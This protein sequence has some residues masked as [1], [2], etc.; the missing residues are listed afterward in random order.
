MNDRNNLEG[1]DLDSMIVPIINF[2][3]LSNTGYANTNTNKS[4]AANIDEALIEMMASFNPDELEEKYF[5]QATL[6]LDGHDFARAVYRTYLKREPEDPDL[7]VDDGVAI[8]TAFV[9]IVRTCPEYE[10]RKHENQ[11]QNQN[12]YSKLKKMVALLIKPIYLLIR[13]IYMILAKLLIESLARLNP[14]KL[15]DELFVLL[16]Y[17]LNCRDFGRSVYRTYLKREPDTDVSVK[18]NYVNRIVF[19]TRVR[20]SSEYMSLW[21]SH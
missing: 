6:S 16:T 7:R 11:N 9:N 2:T 17:I 3:S 14:N 4:S 20:K 8:R 10:N 18:R 5:V 13:P 1:T 12:H 21:F 15:S 19:L